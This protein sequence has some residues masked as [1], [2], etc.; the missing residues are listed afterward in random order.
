[1]MPTLL[2]K[3]LHGFSRCSVVLAYDEEARPTGCYVRDKGISWQKEKV[4]NV[5]AKGMGQCAIVL[6]PGL[7]S[8]RTITLEETDKK[9]IQQAMEYE[10]AATLMEDPNNGFAAYQTYVRDMQTLVL[11]VWCDTQL[12]IGS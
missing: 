10:A 12:L 6:P 7:V 9:I 1:M 8:L 11:L 2:K 5:N 4:Q 3:I